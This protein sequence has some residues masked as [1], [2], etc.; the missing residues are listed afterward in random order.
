MKIRIVD[1]ANKAGVS[2]GTVDRIIHQRGRYSEKTKE[3]VDQA[4]KE[5]GYAPD[6]MARNL[7]LKKEL[8][9]VGMLPNPADTPYWERPYAGIEKAI[10]EL[11]SFKVKIETV[12]FLPNAKDFKKACEQVLKLKPDGVVYCPMFFE[13]SAI[14]A[15]SLDESNIPFVHVNI[16]QANLKPLSYVGQNSIAAGNTAASLCQLALK[17]T[18][19]Y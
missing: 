3:K 7:A 11:Y 1:I 12:L 4:I 19:V 2:T 15:K 8:R 16:Y 18:K 14:F 17:K 10:S 9:I 5:L 6:L 13:E